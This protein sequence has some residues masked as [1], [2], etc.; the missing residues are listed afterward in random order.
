MTLIVLTAVRSIP[1]SPSN[2]KNHTKFHSKELIHGE[3][4]WVRLKGC[5]NVARMWRSDLGVWVIVPMVLE[6]DFKY[7][8]P[9]PNLEKVTMKKSIVIKNG[10]K[11]H[12][13]LN[14]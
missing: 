6:K 4:R 10:Y 11:G 7:V 13:K 2:M 1:P 12:R 8:P 3:K 5:K 9:E 14:T